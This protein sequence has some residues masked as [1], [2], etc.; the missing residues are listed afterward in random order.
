MSSNLRAEPLNRAKLELGT[1]LKF[2]L[3]KC[4][5][6]PLDVVMGPNSKKLLEGMIA[7][8]NDAIVKDAEKLLD[9]INK[10]GEV[11]VKEEY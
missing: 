4:F 7:A 6:E 11:L 3:R 8:G 1:D 10:H 5:S 2:A 9:F